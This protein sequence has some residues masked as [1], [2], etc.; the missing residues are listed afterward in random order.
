MTYQVPEAVHRA[1]VRQLETFEREA[2]EHVEREQKLR[3]RI[4][5]LEVALNNPLHAFPEGEAKE[6]SR[7]VLEDKR[8]KQ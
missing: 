2:I 8:W 5:S 1:M 3:G 6:S 4:A 7:R